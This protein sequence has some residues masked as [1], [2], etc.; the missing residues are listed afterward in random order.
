VL[1]LK[2]RVRCR[3][4]GARGRAVVSIKWGKSV[5][6]QHHRE[7]KQYFYSGDEETQLASRQEFITFTMFW[8]ATLFVVSEGWKELKVVDAEINTL[9][10][11]HLD[12]L[13]LFRNAVYHFQKGDKKHTQFFDPDKFNWAERMQAA[14][15][16]FFTNKG[17]YDG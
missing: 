2:D 17:W 4:C 15:R 6:Y 9:V 3:G 8:F 14:Y 10:D 5:M 12:S 7:L 13:R 11:H 16:R 1:D